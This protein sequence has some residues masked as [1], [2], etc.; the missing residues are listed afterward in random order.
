MPS[1]DAPSGKMHEHHAAPV[2]QPR[3]V[4]RE[5]PSVPREKV[6]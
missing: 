5:T 2:R 4:A 6:P 3:A 1:A